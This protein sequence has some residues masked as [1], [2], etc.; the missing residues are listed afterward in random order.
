MELPVGCSFSE[1]LKVFVST[2]R[3]RKLCSC[4]TLSLELPSTLVY[5]YPTV[6]A[7]T[8]MIV[9]QLPARP[10]PRQSESRD[11]LPSNAATLPE[12]VAPQGI[13]AVHHSA[14]II[15]LTSGHLFGNDGQTAR[16]KSN[17]HAVRG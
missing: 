2:L 5:D 3:R 6:A 12:N 17:Q 1:P 10:Q 16:L 13:A 7:I 8:E 9:K 4:R 14:M 11:L 15:L